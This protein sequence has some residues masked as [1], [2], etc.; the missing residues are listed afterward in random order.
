MI[1]ILIGVIVTILDQIT[2][3]IV[4]NVKPTGAKNP[5]FIDFRLTYN[6]GAAFSFMDDNTLFLAILSLAASIAIIYIIFKFI[7]FK[8]KKLLHISMGL[9]LGGCVGNMI[10]RFMTVFNWRKGVIDFIDVYIGSWHFPG[11]FNVADFFLVT[12]V[13]LI[14]LD[15]IIDEIKSH[16][17]NDK[18]EERLSGDDNE[19]SSK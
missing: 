10:D 6:Q 3:I 15:I 11:T 1:A 16:K 13:C 9:I 7:P 18:S 8:P 14:I 19:N 12:G 2:K 17:N 5:G 4:Q